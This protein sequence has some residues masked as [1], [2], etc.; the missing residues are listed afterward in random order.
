MSPVLRLRRRRRFCGVHVA[1]PYHY[2]DNDPLNKADPL[3]LRPSD[4]SFDPNITVL[5]A[6]QVCVKLWGVG[7]C[8]GVPD[9]DDVL[10]ALVDV[11]LLPV[12]AYVA[13][14][15]FT[16]DQLARLEAMLL[17][18][19]GV[20]PSPA[21]DVL[22]AILA[23]DASDDGG[24]IRTCGTSGLGLSVWCTARSRY[25]TQEAITIGHFINCRESVNCTSAV[26]VGLLHHELVHV[27]QWEEV[28]DRYFALYPIA[29]A[30]A[31]LEARRTGDP[32]EC[33]HDFEGPAYRVGPVDSVGNTRC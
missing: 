29:S 23:V 31:A 3:G 18:L 27:E 21:A 2:A 28:G 24:Q 15:Q 13:F 7:G 16:Q 17:K 20:S 11:A 9:P 32:Y 10:D 14:Q 12:E 6:G 19:F 26:G 22:G 5:P 25:V 8:V 4:F 30:R 33:V 1:N